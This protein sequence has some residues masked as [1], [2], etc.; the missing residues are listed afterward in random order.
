MAF[1][2]V[3]EI[4][5]TE[6]SGILYYVIN[7]EK[8]K[9]DGLPPVYYR[10][11][12][13]LLDIALHPDFSKNKLIYFTMSSSTEGKN[14]GGNTELY[15]GK[16]DGTK[17][18]EVKLLYKATPKSKNPN[19]WG[20]RI[21]FDEKGYL[22][23]GIGD[24]GDRDLNPQDITRDAGKIYRLN[25]DGSIP[26]DNPFV[27]ELSAKKAIFSYGHRNPQG[28]VIHPKTGE[29][30]EHEH[31]PRGGD[32]INIIK[33]GLNYG[34][35]KITYGKDYL[36]YVGISPLGKKTSGPGLEK[37]LYYWVPSI[38]PSGMAFSTSDVYK[39]WKGNLFVGSLK[40]NYLERLIIEKNK[41]VKR[42]KILDKIGRVRNVVEGPDG[43]LYLGVE[44]KGIIR[45]LPK[46]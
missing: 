6:Q 25:L 9:V 12:G 24:R 7:G 26:K 23:F 27:N 4:L 44:G 5:I 30:W 32:E 20:S 39:D 22:Y 46:G 8:N 42:E 10:G 41:V 33:K 34:W 35:P 2:N 18:N 37:P 38:A 3:N 17:L 40:F 16:L 36:D 21:V 14:M 31:G 19:H 45:I 15:I 1:I 11:Q 13:G 29:I 28:M 43:Y